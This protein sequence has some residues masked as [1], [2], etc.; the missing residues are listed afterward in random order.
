MKKIIIPILAAAMS[1]ACQD[2]KTTTSQSHMAIVKEAKARN[3]DSETIDRIATLKNNLEAD[4][5]KQAPEKIMETKSETSTVDNAIP[6][7][8]SVEEVLGAQP[9]V[10][11]IVENFIKD[12]ADPVTKNTTRNRITRVIS[13]AFALPELKDEK[14]NY[15]D[16]NVILPM[17]KKSISWQRLGS[18]TNQKAI[19]RAMEHVNSGGLALAIDTSVAYGHVVQLLPGA[20]I[21]SGSWEM[22]LPKVLSLSNHKPERSFC[23]KSLAY[24]FKKSDDIEIYIEKK[25]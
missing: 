2:I 5:T 22:Q 21:K 8:K 3:T 12:K 16:Y 25:Y 20:T 13:E 14:G 17:I 9:D 15:V 6:E 23:D 24:A 19:D 11:V 4:M 1:I 7:I 18:A 10:T